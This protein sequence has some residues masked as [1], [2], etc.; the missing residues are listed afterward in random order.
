MVV[1]SILL[2]LYSVCLLLFWAFTRVM[3]A[4]LVTISQLPTINLPQ[5]LLHGQHQDIILKDR[6]VCLWWLNDLGWLVKVH[7]SFWNAFPDPTQPTCFFLESGSL[8]SSLKL[9]LFYH[10][11][12]RQLENSLLGLLNIALNLMHLCLLFI[13]VV[14]NFRL[15]LQSRSCLSFFQYVLGLILLGFYKMFFLQKPSAPFCCQGSRQWFNENRQGHISFL[16]M[17]TILASLCVLDFLSTRSLT[18]D[19]QLHCCHLTAA[20][21]GNLVSS[22]VWKIW[23]WNEDYKLCFSSVFICS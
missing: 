18:Y 11:G 7:K 13:L 20:V 9:Q 1:P 15:S 2:S 5:K 8:P 19:Q 4:T 12:T 21:G 22:F 14:S 6:D 10:C 16:E 23:L 17:K 3:K